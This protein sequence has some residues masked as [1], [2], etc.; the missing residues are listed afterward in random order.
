M[1]VGVTDLSVEE[2]AEYLR[3]QKKVGWR[4]TGTDVFES[5]FSILPMVPGELAVVRK[6]DDVDSI[7]MWHRSDEHYTGWHMP[8]GY[9]LLGESD[10]EWVRRV[11]K[12]ETSLELG[13]FYQIRTFNTPPSTGWVPNHQMAHFF[14]CETEGEPT[15][16]KFFPLAELPEDTLGHHKKYIEWLRAYVMRTETM[17]EHGIRYDHPPLP[18]EKMPTWGKWAI[19][20]RWEEEGQEYFSRWGIFD[21]LDGALEEFSLRGSHP[22]FVIDDQGLQIL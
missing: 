20:R 5:F 22:L 19:V 2:R 21:T 10:E 9:L 7:L 4:R 15:N 13:H 11:L 12:K 8:G 1:Q 3:L 16:G 14:L 18:V 17:C 6:I